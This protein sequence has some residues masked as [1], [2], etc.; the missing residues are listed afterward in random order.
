VGARVE[1][2]AYDSF[3]AEWI[4]GATAHGPHP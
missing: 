3:D 2:F 4:G 1:E